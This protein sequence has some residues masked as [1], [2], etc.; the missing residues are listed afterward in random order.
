MKT[1]FEIA[2]LG[3]V[4]LYGV[5]LLAI[6]LLASCVV[7]ACLGSSVTLAAGI[8]TLLVLGPSLLLARDRSSILAS[9]AIGISAMGF[10]A[11][12]IHLTGGMIE[13]HFHIFAALAMLLVYGRV[14]PIL[15]AATTIALHH[16]IF[17]IWLPA[18]VFNYK[19]SFGIVLLH[20]FFVVFEVVPLCWIARNFGKSIWARGL[21][22]DSLTGTADSV[23]TWSKTV[24]RTGKLLADSA[25]RAAT[26][27]NETSLTGDEVRHLAVENCDLSTK[28]VT[29]LTQADEQIAA[30]DVDLK[31][32]KQ[33]VSEM[34]ASSREIGSINRLIE[35]MAFQT[36][37][38]ALNA[39]VEAARA[40]EAGAGFAV[41]AGEVRTLAQKAK[42]A[43]ADT[44]SL[45]EQALSR[46]A[47]GQASV[48]SVVSSVSL[49]ANKA[50]EALRD[51]ERIHEASLR[52][53]KAIDCVTAALEQLK[54]DSQ[55][56]AS[57]AREAAGSGASLT[58]E[59]RNLHDIVNQ[60]ARA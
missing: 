7:A 45:V 35:D 10:S 30:V 22:Q 18:S 38:L 33:T 28:A 57:V 8:G 32:M 50:T 19:A 29:L 5:A 34:A 4:N 56:N 25:E 49:L 3:K 17:W 46:A 48:E 47:A 53:G 24:G 58:E 39:A 16:V 36:N 20:A 27:V 54:S 37:I 55:R 52:Q 6:H 41:V 26:T 21:V 9:A 51:V 11:L 40:G 13:A 1:Q 42:N 44:T 2:Y 12:L 59:A 14:A 31:A 60:L 15:A 23:E 43:A